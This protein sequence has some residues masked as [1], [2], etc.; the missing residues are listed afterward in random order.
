MVFRSVQV[1]DPTQPVVIIGLPGVD[2]EALIAGMQIAQAAASPSIV[3]QAVFGRPALKLSVDYGSLFI[4]WPASAA[5][6]VLQSSDAMR[7][8]GWTTVNAT[9][10]TKGTQ[11]TV[12]L[13]LSASQ[14]IYRLYH[15]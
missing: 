1:T 3:G 12:T 14:R 13:P 4:S 10:V 7:P 2:R 8:S 15:P 5:G 9:P 11:V 6:F